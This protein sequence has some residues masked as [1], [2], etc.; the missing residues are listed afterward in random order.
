MCGLVPYCQYCITER[1]WRTAVAP[2]ASNVAAAA[3]TVSVFPWWGCFHSTDGSCP[4][5]ARREREMRSR[6]REGRCS[7]SP[8]L[9]AAVTCCLCCGRQWLTAALMPLLL[10][11][12][13]ISVGFDHEEPRT[14]VGLRLSNGG[15]M[16][17]GG[18]ASPAFFST[19]IVAVSTTRWWRRNCGPGKREWRRTWEV[20]LLENAGGS[21][22]RLEVPTKDALG[23][24]VDDA[25]GELMKLETREDLEDPILELRFGFS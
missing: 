4:A 19:M 25:V 17:T 18:D 2:P 5:R 10:L 14:A 3:T 16:E 20:L 24:R 13:A 23:R 8:T 1:K 21:R 12:D 22:Q 11:K 9:T 7:T 6:A 15:R